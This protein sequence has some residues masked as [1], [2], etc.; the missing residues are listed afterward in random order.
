MILPSFVVPSFFFSSVQFQTSL[1]SSLSLSLS[2]RRSFGIPPEL[3]TRRTDAANADPISW[4]SFRHTP[5]DRPR[6]VEPRTLICG[7]NLGS[8]GRGRGLGRSSVETEPPCKL[9]G[10]LF[11]PSFWTKE[12][13]ESVALRRSD[14]LGIAP[15]PRSLPQMLKGSGREGCR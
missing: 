9:F 12:W 8:D 4:P 6:P 15:F 2:F 7:E 11:F 1:I 5:P 3:L 10:L 13:S 14:D